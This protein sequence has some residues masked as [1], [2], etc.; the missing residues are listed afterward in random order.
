MKHVHAHANQGARL[1][2]VFAFRSQRSPGAH[3]RLKNFKHPAQLL[4]QFV[5]I[6][7]RAQ[8]VQRQVLEDAEQ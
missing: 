7:S 6:F 1:R 8:D 4:F 2:V 5:P 3:A